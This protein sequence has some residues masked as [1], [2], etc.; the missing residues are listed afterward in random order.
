MTPVIGPRGRRPAAADLRNRL[1]RARHADDR[2]RLGV[3]R[4]PER[5]PAVLELAAARARNGQRRRR[6]DAR[7]HDGNAREGMGLGL[8]GRP[9]GSAVP[10]VRHDQLVSN[11]ITV[12]IGGGLYGVNQPTLRQ[13]MAVFLLKARHG[14]CYVPPPCTGAVRRRALPLDVRRLDRGVRRRRD[15]RRMRR[16]TTTAR[17]TRSGGDQMAVFILKAEHGPSYVPP[18]CT[19]IYSDVPAP[20]S[21]PT[22]SSSLAR[23]RSPEAAAVGTTARATPTRAARWPCFMTKAFNLP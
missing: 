22:G 15:H 5:S 16:R 19:G 7:R 21:S 20:P 12:G 4:L 9:G 2:R 3:L 23:R 11:A 17:R 6:H 1:R 14:L 10:L 18:A 13:Q 8:P